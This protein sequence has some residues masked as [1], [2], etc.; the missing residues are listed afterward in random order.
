[1]QQRG[2]LG[3]LFSPANFS[4]V[5]SEAPFLIL[6]KPSSFLPAS[7]SLSGTDTRELCGFHTHGIPS[8]PPWLSLVLFGY[9]NTTA[10]LP[11]SW[12][13]LLWP[14]HHL[15]ALRVS[16]K[17]HAHPPLAP[18]FPSILSPWDVPL[19]FSPFSASPILE[20]WLLWP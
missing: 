15:H 18:D 19:N 1:M 9:V 8:L 20:G 16:Y 6:Y 2:D 5:K 14:G 13:H 10:S 4:F 11:L 7:L 3:C 12:S 17:V